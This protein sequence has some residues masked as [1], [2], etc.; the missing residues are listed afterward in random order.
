MPS[1][2]PQTAHI[3]QLLGNQPTKLNLPGAKGAANYKVDVLILVVE[4]L[5]PHGAQGWQEAATLY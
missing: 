3:F 4:E 5:L 2:H 1:G